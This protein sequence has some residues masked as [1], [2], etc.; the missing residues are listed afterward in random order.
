VL[1]GNIPALVTPFALTGEL[2]TDRLADVVRWHLASG[3]DGICIAG[4]NG[5]A[6]S[7]AH[8]ERRIIAEVAVRE[9]AGRVPV[10]MGTSG[11][12]TKQT[13]ALAEIAATA[14]VDALL[15]QPQ[16]YVLKATT[17]EIVGR[18]SAVAA[19]V[20]LPIVLYNSPRRTGLNLDIATLRAVCD[21]APVVAVK[22]SNRDFFHV[23][24]VIE[25]FGERLSILIGPAPFIC[26]GLALGAH[27][28]ISS[29][30]ELLGAGARSLTAIASTLPS[31]EARRLHFALTTTYEALMDAGTWPA[32][33]KA[34]LNMVGVPAGFPREPVMPLSAEA[35]DRLRRSLRH[36]GVAVVSARASV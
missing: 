22:E 15:L 23:T 25:E 17:A 7:L 36:A 33:L 14:A 4:D 35:E 19:A 5:E 13:I 9:A 32:A 24:H 30:P 31:L 3:V 6:W 27:G 10:I 1:R 28:F 12:T 34:A 29:G 20:P 21:A 11:I 26:P 16:S 2:M 8:D 18:F